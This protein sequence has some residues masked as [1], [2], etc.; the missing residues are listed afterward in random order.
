MGENVRQS[1][2]QPVEPLP[3]RDAVLQEKAA[4]LIDDRGSLP[5]QAVA[6]A[7]QRLQIELLVRLRWYAPRCR[8]L[9]GFGNRMRISKIILVSLP[10]WLGVDRWHLPHVVAEGEQ[11]TIT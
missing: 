5:Y 8:T 9:H 1:M 11:R 10:E 6:H 3:H 4:D 7:M 2:A